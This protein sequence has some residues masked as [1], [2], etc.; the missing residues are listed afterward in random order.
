MIFRKYLG[1][2]ASCILQ[3]KYAKLKS[4][5]FSKVYAA[6]IFRKVDK[7]HVL[8]TFTFIIY[9]LMYSDQSDRLF[10]DI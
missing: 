3:E 1:N 5:K 2:G 6:F 7:Y 10:I 8:T 9:I 4:T